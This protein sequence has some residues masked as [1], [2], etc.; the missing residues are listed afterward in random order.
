MATLL[1][2]ARG[3]GVTLT[4]AHARKLYLFIFILLDFTPLPSQSNTIGKQPTQQTEL[5]L[6]HDAHITHVK[7]YYFFNYTSKPQ[8]FYIGRPIASNYQNNNPPRNPIKPTL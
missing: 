1:A 7:G 4:H 6:L 8:N 5:V 2:D 3:G